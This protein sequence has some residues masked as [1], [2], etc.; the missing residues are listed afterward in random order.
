VGNA[1]STGGVRL[2][3]GRGRRKDA[4]PQPGRGDEGDGGGKRRGLERESGWSAKDSREEVGYARYDEISY[5]LQKY[6]L[7]GTCT[8]PHRPGAPRRLTQQPTAVLHSK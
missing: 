8:P 2:V 7:P 6:A 5:G 1:E 4:A 3:K